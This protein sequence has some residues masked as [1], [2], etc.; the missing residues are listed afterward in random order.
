MSRLVLEETGLLPHRNPGVMTWSELQRLRPYAPSMGMMLETTSRTLW[1]EPGGA[2]YGSPDKDPELRL[3]VL[4][5]AGRSRIPFSTGVLL[6]IGETMRDRAESLF[7]IRDAHERWGHVQE[8]IVQ[9]FRTKSGTAMQNE[10]DLATQQY[11]AAVAVSRLVM[12]ADAHI[13]VPPNL[14][15]PHEKVQLVRLGEVRR[16][17]AVGLRT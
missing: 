11:V 16:H 12:G 6:G 17:L 1:S 4:E 7:A 5:D 8:T 15:E 9:N 10:P 2:H 3:R 14:T 13:Q